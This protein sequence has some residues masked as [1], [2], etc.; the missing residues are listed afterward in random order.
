ME[1]KKIERNK[2]MKIDTENNAI[3][4]TY[5]IKIIASIKNKDIEFSNSLSKQIIIEYDI[6]DIANIEHRMYELE[7][8]IEQYIENVKK[9]TNDLE[10]IAENHGYEII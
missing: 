10:F 1:I 9:F 6:K 8:E 4:L 3:L 5:N 7:R 2:T